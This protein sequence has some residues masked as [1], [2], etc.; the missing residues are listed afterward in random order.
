MKHE[1]VQE[2]KM[3][4]LNPQHFFW[5]YSVYTC[6]VM[7]MMMMMMMMMIM[8]MM[9]MITMIMIIVIMIMMIMIMIIFPRSNFGS[10]L[11]ELSDRPTDT[12]APPRQRRLRPASQRRLRP[13]A[14]PRKLRPLAS[15]AA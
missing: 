7:M 1:I 2:I 6:E 3:K 15:R 12:E 9:M 5:M 10:S 14:T 13:A 4:N 11:F 8:I